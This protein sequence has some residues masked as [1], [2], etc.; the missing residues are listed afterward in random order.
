MSLSLVADQNVLQ[1][2]SYLAPEDCKNFL[3]TQKFFLNVV[4]G[5]RYLVGSRLNKL[6]IYTGR[7][8]DK[9]MA[10]EAIGNKINA[11]FQSIYI[12]QISAMENDILFSLGEIFLSPLHT[13]PVIEFYRPI[14]ILFA[15]DFDFAHE[16]FIRII[17][18][19]TGGAEARRLKLYFQINLLPFLNNHSVVAS[20]IENSCRELIPLFPAHERPGVGSQIGFAVSSSKSGKPCIWSFC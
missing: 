15:N 12:P 14:A 17:D 1:I 3:M 16:M 19:Q 13:K 7:V 5:A 11:L 10:L 6:A 20:K 2:Y 8:L 18:S 9:K 4:Y